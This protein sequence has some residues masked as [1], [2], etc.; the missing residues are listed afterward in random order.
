MYLSSGSTSPQSTSL[1]YYGQSIRAVKVNKQLEGKLSLSWET[2]NVDASSHQIRL[3]VYYSGEILQG[4]S[5]SYQTSSGISV[6]RYSSQPYLEISVDPNTNT[7]D[8]TKSVTITYNGVNKTAYVYQSGD[9]IDY[10]ETTKVV[11]GVSVEEC[12][13]GD[14]VYDPGT[15]FSYS[16]SGSCNGTIDVET[17]ET[18]YWVSGDT[19]TG[20]SDTSSYSIRSANISIDGYCSGDQDIVN[21][22][23]ITLTDRYGNSYDFEL[24][25]DTYGANEYIED[26]PFHQT[27]GSDDV[28]LGSVYLGG[29]I[30][31]CF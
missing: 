19:T 6:Y 15:D 2:Q 3:Y 16:Y 8:V 21:S 12:L 24:S 5:V 31:F 11:T 14:G 4:M 23:S 13:S 9:E 26:I 25:E 10:T 28:I 20:S 22:A 17:T 27:D 18:E 7:L 30:E 29:I 1:R